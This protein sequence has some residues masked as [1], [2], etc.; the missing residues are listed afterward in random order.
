[1]K[2][3][4]IIIHPDLEKSVVNKRWKEE[5]RKYPDNY[6]LHDLYEVYPDEEIDI[7]REQRL[8]E[9]HDNVVFQFPLYWFS[10]PPLLKKWFDEVLTYGWAYGSKSG[11]NVG[12]KKVALAISAGIDEEGYSENG[13]YRYTL[14]ELT[15]P[16]QLT[17]EYAK[18]D[19]K[20]FY[21]YYGLERNA[22]PNGSGKVYPVT[23]TFS[24]NYKIP[25][26]EGTAKK[27][28]ANTWFKRILLL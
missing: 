15:R 21:V 22:S 8:I 28:A 23:L 18:A 5:L 6:T 20:F 4:V 16:F 10:S 19:Y 9:S 25:F 17:F 13:I 14:E 11:Y 27:S 2:T 3:L 1:M 26:T 24:G 12:G 7:A